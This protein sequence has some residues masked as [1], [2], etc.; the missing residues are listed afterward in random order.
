MPTRSRGSSKEL[1]RAMRTA[2]V[3][4]TAEAQAAHVG[5]SM[6]V[7]DILAVLYSGGARIDPTRPDWP[8]RDRVVVS[9]GHASAAVLACLGIS[10][11]F[12]TK[13]LREYCKDG[14]M[15]AGHVTRSGVP[16]VDFSTGSLG[17]GLP[18]A[19]GTALAAKRQG[20]DRRAFCVLSDGE[21]DEGSVWEAALFASHHQLSSVIVLIDRNGIQSLGSTEDTIALEPLED[22]WKAFGWST[23]RIDGHDHSQIASAIRRAGRTTAPTCIVAETTKGKG[24]TFM[25]DQVVWH[26]R[27]LSGD[28]LA[29]AIE[30]VTGERLTPADA[31]DRVVCAENL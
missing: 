1:A 14:S 8:D 27:S 3:L 2:I 23:S 15:L 17:H 19:V 7:A 24:V 21:L 13:R 25:E 30:Q 12:E 28:P 16:G 22:K 18:F 31:W 10:G 9:K 6:S 29:D 5:S 4:M 20:S 11:Y 26:Y